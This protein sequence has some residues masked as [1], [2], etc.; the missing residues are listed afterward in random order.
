MRRPSAAWAAALA[1]LALAAAGARAAAAPASET[2][3]TASELALAELDRAETGELRRAMAHVEAEA[4]P[5]VPVPAWTDVRDYVSGHGLRFDG[6]ALLAGLLRYLAGEV[7][8]SLGT[9]GQLLALAVLA[10]LLAGLRAGAEDTA[11]ARLGEAVV[12]LVLAGV[13]LSAFLPAIGLARAAVS[14]L[15]DLLLASL[16][17]LVTLVAGSGGVTTA[18]LL[19]PLVLS[20]ADLVAFLAA[21]VAFPLLFVGAVLELASLF[22]APFGAFGAARLLRQAALGLLALALTAYVGLVAVLGAAGAVADGV[23]LRAAKFAAATFVPVIGK[24]LADAA[25]LVAGASLLVRSGVGV[26]ALILVLL[27]VAFPLLKLVSLV[28]AFRA[29]GA[30]VEP[31]G[32]HG[33]AR[34]LAAMGDAV[35]SASLVV[36][37][38]GL[39]TFLSIAALIV[40]GVGVTALR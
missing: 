9:L 17:L 6:P 20:A 33:A 4:P 12:L 25:D 14:D 28:A 22:S 36:A 40:A 7:G 16:P 2:V 24:T 18:G 34:A 39:M 11:P 13:A 32:A 31:I 3:P 37:A 23:A 8:Q 38:V 15:R 27:A 35:A 30:L 1:L 5:Y 10:A 21:D 29:G 26:T 19:N